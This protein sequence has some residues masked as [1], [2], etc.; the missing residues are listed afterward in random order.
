VAAKLFLRL[1]LSGRSVVRPRVINVDAHPAYASA[2]AELKQSGELG[3]RCRYRTSPHLNNIIK[4][5]H[6]FIRKRITPSLG[7][8]SAQDALQTIRRLRSNARNR[9]G[10][11]RWLAWG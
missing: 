6:R 1:A 8:C 10:Q 4:Q 11:V 7:F 5:D 2:I 3:R 9:E